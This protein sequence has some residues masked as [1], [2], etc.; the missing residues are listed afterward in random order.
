MSGNT[1]SAGRDPSSGRFT[2]GNRWWEARSSHGAN[3]KFENAELLQDACLQYFDWNEANPLYKDQLVTFQG[4][5][6]HEPV[7]Q[8]RA[9]T[10]GA[11]CMFIDIGQDT[12]I[13]W[14]NTRSD[15][16]KVISW[17]ESVIYRQKFEGA[18]ADLLNANIIARDLG[19]ADKKEHASPD[20]TMS[21]KPAF[22]LSAAPPEVL[23]WFV[24][25][26]DK[27]VTD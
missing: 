9:M 13:A 7:A 4:C 8:M 10:I 27:D 20:G 2:T 26:R 19:L 3:P 11:L 16:S 24:S 25:Q 14:R 18:S 17:A 21:P 6:S 5:A 22:D 23:E 15:L 12:W 1:I